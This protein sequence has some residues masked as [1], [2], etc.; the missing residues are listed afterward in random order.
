MSSSIY[1]LTTN[2]SL[3]PRVQSSFYI[4]GPVRWNPSQTLVIS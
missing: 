1:H 4:F 2:T 3:T